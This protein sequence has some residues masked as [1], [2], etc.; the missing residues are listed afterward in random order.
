MTLTAA[1]CWRVISRKHN[2]EKPV[3]IMLFVLYF[4][5]L[6]FAQIALFAMGYFLLH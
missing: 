6:V 2:L 4:W 1:V 5:G 3:K